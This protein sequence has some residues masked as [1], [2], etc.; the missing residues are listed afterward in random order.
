[1][2]GFLF[3][4]FL[5]IMMNSKDLLFIIKIMIYC[6]GK[7]HLQKVCWLKTSETVLLLKLCA[8]FYFFLTFICCLEKPNFFLTF[9]VMKIRA[10]DTLK[11]EILFLTQ[12]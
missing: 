11:N 12:N 1:M 9:L 2:W 7:A 6:P 10:I 4:F 8:C 5:N 3:F